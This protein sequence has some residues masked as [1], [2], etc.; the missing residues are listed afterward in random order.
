[1]ASKK[2]HF[3]PL[4]VK[5]NSHVPQKKSHIFPKYAYSG[6]LNPPKWTPP[7][8]AP[9]SRNPPPPPKMAHQEI[10]ENLKNALSFVSLEKV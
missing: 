2:K 9:P 5:S 10:S 1:M 8:R 6:A 4:H 3:S 7:P